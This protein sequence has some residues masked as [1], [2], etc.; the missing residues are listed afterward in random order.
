M[1]PKED[2]TNKINV[3]ETVLLCEF[4]A[5]LSKNSSTMLRKAEE[6][7]YHAL[8]SEI[9]GENEFRRIYFQMIYQMELREGYISNGDESAWGIYSEICDFHTRG[10]FH[11]EFARRVRQAESIRESAYSEAVANTIRHIQNEL[12]NENLSIQLLARYAY[13]TPNYLAARF[14]KETGVTIG[15]YCLNQRMERGKELLMN[16][17]L[18]LNE[19]A[20]MVGYR[21][22]DY[23]SKIFKR[24][25]GCTPT[26]YR[27]QRMNQQINFKIS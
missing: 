16:K 24:E 9:F 5:A 11:E 22:A 8:Q 1:H 7:V 6:R 13:L 2:D 20:R 17:K 10:E 26:R 23:F 4:F 18:K 15:Q 12:N 19:I 27:E 3:T 14:K 25:V 21:D